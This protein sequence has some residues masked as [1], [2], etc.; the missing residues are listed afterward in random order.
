MQVSRAYLGLFVER[1]IGM[2]NI[3]CMDWMERLR[4]IHAFVLSGRPPC[5]LVGWCLSGRTPIL[6]ISGL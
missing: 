2:Q 3:R 4:P 6:Y 5:G 1:A